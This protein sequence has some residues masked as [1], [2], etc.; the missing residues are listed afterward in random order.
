MLGHY[1][2]YSGAY[3]YD[4]IQR[5]DKSLW[6]DIDRIAE[7]LKDLHNE[8]RDSYYLHDK[9]GELDH[10]GVIEKD[11]DLVRSDDDVYDMVARNTPTA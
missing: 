5:G 1:Q 6:L 4:A 2:K 9:L 11:G 8:E 3:Y 7:N 10:V